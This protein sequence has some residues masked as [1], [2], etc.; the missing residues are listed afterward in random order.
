[1]PVS[2]LAMVVQ[3][4]VIQQEHLLVIQ[5]INQADCPPLRTSMVMVPPTRCIRKMELSIT[6][7]NSVPL[8]VRLSMENPFEFVVSAI[9]LSLVV[10]PT[11]EEPM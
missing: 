11:L 7:R 9:S 6:D 3:R 5:M 10:T 4:Q 8:M 1:M 2:V